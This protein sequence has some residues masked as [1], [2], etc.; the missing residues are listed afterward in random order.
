M[1]GKVC[2]PQQPGEEMLVQGSEVLVH[3]ATFHRLLISTLKG[4]CHLIADKDPLFIPVKHP[5][6]APELGRIPQERN[7]PLQLQAQE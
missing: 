6:V 1:V 3:A 7:E 4:S 2:G 5:S